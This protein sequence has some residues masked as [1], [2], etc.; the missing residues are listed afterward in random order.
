MEG[1]DEMSYLQYN[2]HPENCVCGRCDNTNKMALDPVGWPQS[3][4]LPEGKY[5]VIDGELFKVDPGVSPSVYSELQQRIQKLES[6]KVQDADSYALFKKT[7]EKL[8]ALVKE[9]KECFESLGNFTPDLIRLSKIQ[10][11]LK[12][13]SE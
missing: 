4:S 1:A 3:Q 5:W 12:K 11:W 7:Y 2:Q 8:E 9:A 6:D 13:V 10:A